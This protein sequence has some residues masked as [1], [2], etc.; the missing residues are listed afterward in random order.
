MIVAPLDIGD[1]AYTAAGS[2]IDEDVPARR[3]LAIHRGTSAQRGRV[4]KAEAARQ[5]RR[6]LPQTSRG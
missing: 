6:P 5:R 2:V 3:D 1:G 4:G